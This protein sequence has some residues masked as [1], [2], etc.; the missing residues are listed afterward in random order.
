VNAAAVNS[1]PAPPAAPAS[2]IG[3]S[4]TGSDPH[5]TCETRPF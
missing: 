2:S 3:Q 1:E 4:A 5:S